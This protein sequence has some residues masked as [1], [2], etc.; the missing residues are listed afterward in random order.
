MS[1]DQ[2]EVVDLTEGQKVTIVLDSF[3][4]EEIQGEIEFISYTP[5]A[6]EIGA[7][8][9]ITIKLAS[10]VDPGKVRVGMTGDARFILSEKEDVLYV[11]NQFVNTDKKGKYVFKNTND[12]KIYVEVGTEGEER[13]EIMGDIKEG[14]VLYD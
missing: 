3:I 11:P 2:G 12:N 5:M 1:A 7:V 4:D 8:Y 13:I 10:N 14:D 9:K 6:G